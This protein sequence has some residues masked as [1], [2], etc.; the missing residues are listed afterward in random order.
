M[1]KEYI[2]LQGKFYL[3]ELVNGVASTMR[4]LGNVPDF[5]LLMSLNIK[6][7]HLVSVLLTSP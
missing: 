6:N 5:E 4:H 7:Q 3:S 1:A 2:S